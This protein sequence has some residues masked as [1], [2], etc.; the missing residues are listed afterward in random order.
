MPLDENAGA[1]LRDILDTSTAD[2][3]QSNS[4]LREESR[5]DQAE[6]VRSQQDRARQA[7]QDAVSMQL[8]LG[9]IGAQ[10]QQTAQ[11]E[12]SNR[13]NEK[14]Q[15]QAQIREDL[16]TL[17]EQRS[18]TGARRSVDRA[19]ARVQLTD[20]TDAILG[21]AASRR[22]ELRE[23]L[24]AF[25]AQMKTRGPG[26]RSATVSSSKSS[27]T[28]RSSAQVVRAPTA[29]PTIRSAATLPSSASI[30]ATVSAM[31][32][33]EPTVTGLRRRENVI[34]KM[35]GANPG[36][37]IKGLQDNL[38]LDANE[39]RELLR[40]LVTS[41]KIAVIDGAYRIVQGL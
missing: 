12:I 26:R 9:Q 36:I 38:Y 35:I 31:G 13:V 29:K 22:S 27:S 18:L 14:R 19:Q 24:S 21:D 6:R 40:K 5:A 3:Q 2:R 11:M 30:K 16:E 15:R 25:S 17:N 1:A 10:R 34:L 33:P 28:G 20:A 7:A 41:G 39:L 32:L 4:R 37:T 23:D 8:H